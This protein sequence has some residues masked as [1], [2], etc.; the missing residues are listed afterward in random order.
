[1]RSLAGLA[2]RTLRRSARRYL[3]T[4]VGA[5]LGVAVLFAILVTSAASREALRAAVDGQT[6]RADVIVTPAGA[7]D[8]FLPPDVAG[9]IR[10]LDGVEEVVSTVAFRSAVTPAGLDEVTDPASIRERTVSVTGTGADFGV[11]NELVRTEGRDPASGA[12]EVLVPRRFADEVDVG[13][14]DVVEL[15]TPAGPVPVTVVGLLADRGAATSNQGRVV[16]TSDELARAL[17]GTSDGTSALQVVLTDG[18]DTGAWIDANRDALTGVAVQD[19]ADVAAGFAQFIE[20]VTGAL[21]LVAAVAVFIGG[22][23][24]YLTFSLAVTERTRVLGTLRALGATARRVQ[25]VVVIEAALLGALCGLVGLAVGYVL[26]G[27]AV[28]VVGGLLDLDLGSV[29]AP[30]GLAVLSFAVG[31]AV[32]ALAALVPARRASRIDPVSAMRGGSL[33]VERAPRRWI[34]PGLLATGAALNLTSATLAV[35]GVA[36]LLVLTGA[37]LSVHLT[38]GPVARVVGRVT[39]RLAPG[40]GEIALRHLQ[41]ERTRSSFTLALVMVALAVSLSVAATNAS[42]QANLDRI[43]DRQVGAIQVGARGAVDD[44][45]AVAEE[46]ASVPGV[47]TVSPVRF[48]A[49]DVSGVGDDGR[50]AVNTFVQ[51]IHPATYFE[52][53]S[54]PFV[55]GDDRSARAALAAGGAVILPGPEANRF[56]VG[57]GDTVEL[58]TRDGREPFEVVGVYETLGGGFGAVL[59][60]VDL[61]RVGAGRVNGFVVGTDGT[62]VE[63]VAERVEA[64]VAG[65]RQLVVDSPADTRAFLE[66]QVAGF[67]GIA[68][69]MLVVALGISLLGLA[70]TLVVTVLD[71]TREIGVLR[72]TGA[73]RRQVRRMVTAEAT[74]MAAVALVLAVPLGALL[75]VGIIDAQRAAIADGL[76]YTFPLASIVPLGLITLVV[77]AVASVLPARRAGRLE[78]VDALRFE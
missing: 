19:A 33:A 73:R 23:L 17:L 28:G 75:T 56:G 49:V 21:T 76:D 43:L 4:A 54:F 18:T 8:S 52:T 30:A 7:F 1:M 24:V 63:E 11:V 77:A 57:L 5:S 74:T 72:S 47:G 70:N 62:D 9:A 59:G 53:A 2:T 32:A 42:M 55:E 34:G 61:D 35:T 22:F 78:I 31:V 48:G 58:G 20:G 10:A 16:Y 3:L 15:T 66:A 29:G 36:M 64:A 51:V 45:D 6:G 67:F 60:E 12:R 71:R 44:A 69:A 68:Y 41:R 13:T 26:A 38:I 46:L 65:P 27:A 25:R 39:A 50:G 14:G 37:V 40:T